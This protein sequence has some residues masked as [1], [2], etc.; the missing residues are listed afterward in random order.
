MS[1]QV[2]VVMPAGVRD[3]AR[4]S[5]GNAYDTRVCAGLAER[6][7]SVREHEVDGPW[8]AWDRDAQARLAR[9]LGSVPDGDVVFVDGLV[10]STAP[11]V[12]GPAADRVRLGVLVHM[13]LGHAFPDDPGVVEAERRVLRGA[14]VVVVT[15]A[16]TRGWLVDAYRLDPARLRVAVPGADRAAPTRGS[17]SGGRLL[18]VG[19]VSR[20]K[21][22]DSLMAAMGLLGDL[23]WRLD[24]V[25]SLTI[26]PETV[27]LVL[28]SAR[29]AGGRVRVA[30]PL[31]RG[32][33]EAAY[34]AADL[35]I[36]P[37]RSETYG[38]VVT[39]AL[40]RGIPVVASDVGGT[41]ESVGVA[42]AFG[43]PGLLVAPDDSEG[44]AAAMRAWLT[45]EDVRR[46]LRVAAAVR[47][48]E[49]PTWDATVTAVEKGLLST[50]LAGAVR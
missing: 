40:A 18:T 17:A 33:L 32:Q 25:G 14:A 1:G 49:L 24:C 35:L 46:R 10:G 5:G 20:G 4:P 26:D 22:H 34:A 36:H 37:S 21:G 50:A 43:R 31:R 28:R 3:P 42:G 9:V 48:D 30:G 19:P 16:W 8:P 6:G 15:S 27:V 23:D 44:L 45:D 38:M 13:P 47:R 2:H 29:A 12:L 11:D 7:W 41:W 39:E